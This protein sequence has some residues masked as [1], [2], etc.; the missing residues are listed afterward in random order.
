MNPD[1][2]NEVTIAFFLIQD[3]QPVPYSH[4]SCFNLGQK[5]LQVG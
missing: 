1:K 2:A 5:S 3:K 4:I